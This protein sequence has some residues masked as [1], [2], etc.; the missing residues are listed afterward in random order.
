MGSA[1]GRGA[2][3]LGGAPP[4]QYAQ[5]GGQL[6]GPECGGHRDLDPFG[7]EQRA[8]AGGV[9]EHVV[10]DLVVAAPGVSRGQAAVG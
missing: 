10:V 8:H 3:W 4:D 9:D 1:C 6:L 7:G 5:S 2:G